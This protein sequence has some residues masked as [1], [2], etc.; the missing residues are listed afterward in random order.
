MS[1]GFKTE[2]YDFFDFS[3]A[4]ISVLVGIRRIDDQNITNEDLEE[5]KQFFN[6][7]GK[8]ESLMKMGISLIEDLAILPTSETVKEK[9]QKEFGAEKYNIELERANDN[10]VRAKLTLTNEECLRR[11]EGERGSGVQLLK[12]EITRQVKNVPKWRVLTKIISRIRST[13]EDEEP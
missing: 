3:Q 4:R 11:S 13:R 6:D 9:Y 8:W 7:M 12:E 2:K 5:L 10:L 1:E